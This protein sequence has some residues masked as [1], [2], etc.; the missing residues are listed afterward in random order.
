MREGCELPAPYSVA[1]VTE[2]E[3]IIVGQNPTVPVL[4]HLVRVAGVVGDS[5]TQHSGLKPN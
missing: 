2:A 3:P 5:R 1:A 4:D